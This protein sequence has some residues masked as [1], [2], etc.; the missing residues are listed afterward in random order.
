MPTKRDDLGRNRFTI[1]ESKN[2]VHKF[3]YDTPF[4]CTL[5]NDDYLIVG[6]LTIVP[7]LKYFLDAE[8][9][10]FIDQEP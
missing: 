7:S 10:Y 6:S 1:R 9:L 2:G 4:V 8:L 5:A 3:P